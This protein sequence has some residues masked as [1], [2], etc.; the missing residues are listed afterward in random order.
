MGDAKRRHT[1]MNAP[2]DGARRTIVRVV[3]KNREFL[4]A[5][6]RRH[7]AM[8]TRCLVDRVRNLRQTGIARGVPIGIVET[9]EMVYIQHQQG[10]RHL[11]FGRLAPTR[12]QR[13]VEGAAVGDAGQRIAVR[14][15]AQ[16][17]V[18]RLDAAGLQF[19]AQQ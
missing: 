15:L 19:L 10:H 5:Q 11:F 17:L 12:L 7:V 9:L 8:G 18:L 3:E 1:V 16:P 14:N 13:L 4:A 2:G 6:S